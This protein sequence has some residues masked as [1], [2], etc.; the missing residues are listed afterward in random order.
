METLQQV[1]HIVRFSEKM[2]YLKGKRGKLSFSLLVVKYL[3][4][5]LHSQE[6][7]SP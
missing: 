3:E 2:Y 6:G 4:A 7:R 1:F 5:G